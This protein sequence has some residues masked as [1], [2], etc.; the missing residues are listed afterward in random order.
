MEVVLNISVSSIA[1]SITLPVAM[2]MLLIWKVRRE[3][4][5]FRFVVVFIFGGFVSFFLAALLSRSLLPVEAL[6]LGED[7]SIQSN[8]SEQTMS[9]SAILVSAFVFAALTEEL[10][11]IIA[12]LGSV[13]ICR[14]LLDGGVILTS[15]MVGLG[16]AMLENIFYSLTMESG[17]GLLFGRMFPTISHCTSA[18]IMG[19]LLEPAVRR[20]RP[21]QLRFLLLAFGVPFLLHGLYDTAAFLIE[22]SE[23]PELPDEPTLA[24]LK[25][26]VWIFCPIVLVT[27]VGLV[28][29]TWAGIIIYRLAKRTPVQAREI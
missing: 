21:L 23:F 28:E 1:A 8:V 6:V 11:R 16:F 3:Q 29:L 10:G 19:S 4:S 14:R 27:L 7:E 5:A 25:P 13:F 9:F 2:A 26:L 24:D 12:V 18:M 20:G 22:Y 15:A 17:V